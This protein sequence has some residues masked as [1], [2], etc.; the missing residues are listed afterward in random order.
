MFHCVGDFPRM[1]SRNFGDRVCL[2][3]DE[4]IL[5]LPNEILRFALQR[6]S[7]DEEIGWTGFVAEEWRTDK[8]VVDSG[9]GLAW[10]H[11]TETHE[12]AVVL[13]FQDKRNS[14]V[15]LRMC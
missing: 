3:N 5:D 13:W 11:R 8:I 7:N 6:V 12:G 14:K 4:K 2:S 15:I 1:W 10:V 9:D